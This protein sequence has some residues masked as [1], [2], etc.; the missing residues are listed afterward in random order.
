MLIN[1]TTLCDVQMIENV[2]YLNML[3]KDLDTL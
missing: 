2:I 3:Q 1:K